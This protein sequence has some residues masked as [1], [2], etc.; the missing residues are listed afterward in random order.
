MSQVLNVVTTEPMSGICK[1]CSSYFWISN[2]PELE[3]LLH[4][5]ILWVGNSNRPGE[6]GWPL[7]HI[8]YQKYVDGCDMI[9]IM[10][11][12]GHLKA[13]LLTYLGHSLG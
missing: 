7:F 1:F 12:W 13:S 6:D 4:M 10:G 11:S 5:C 3:V 2:C 8:S 9:Q